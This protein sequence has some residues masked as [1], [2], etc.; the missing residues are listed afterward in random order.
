[1]SIQSESSAEPSVWEKYPGLQIIPPDEIDPSLPVIEFD[2]EAEPCR[3]PV[4]RGV[5]V[6]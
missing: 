4:D 5:K 6:E 2:S 3:K 1:M